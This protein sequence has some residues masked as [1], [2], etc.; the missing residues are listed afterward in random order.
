MGDS[1][2]LELSPN[3]L[4]G[5]LLQRRLMLK[6]SL[7]GV[8]RNL[9]ANEEEISPKL[10]RIESSF[11]TAN[12]KVAELKL[13]RDE[14]QSSA[15]ALIPDVKSTREKL[16][17]DGGMKSLDPKWKKERLFEQ[18]EEIEQQIQTS[19]LDHKAEKTLIERRRKI[20]SENDRWLKDR[21]D[22]NPDMARYIENSRIMSQ[23]YKTADKSHRDM[24]EAVERAQPIYEKRSRLQNELREVRSQLDRARELLLQS[25]KA[26]NYWE[27]RL[28][29]GFDDI[30][31]GFSD[32]LVG[33]KRVANGG[34]SSFAKKGKKKVSKLDSGEEE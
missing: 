7:P 27:K 24:I 15:R 31:P 26:I 2:L 3:E 30:G 6:E 4:A 1:E 25:D 13:K 28:V 23:L 11:E 5:A 8:I 29:E 10:E 33:M 17:E 22:A 9:E 16:M 34:K 32:L 19:A 20:I 21:K 14:S 18:L 12:K